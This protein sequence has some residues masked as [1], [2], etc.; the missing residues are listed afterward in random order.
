MSTER[1]LGLPSELETVLCHAELIVAALQSHERLGR[2][3]A[4]YQAKLTDV[5]ERARQFVNGEAAKMEAAHATA[6]AAIEKEDAREAS[7]LRAEIARLKRQVKPKK[8]TPKAA[9]LARFAKGRGKG[10]K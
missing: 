1:E 5:W 8:K 2:I 7:A 6:I 9:A 3:E 10:R 4:E